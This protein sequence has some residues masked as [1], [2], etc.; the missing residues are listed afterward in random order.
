MFEVCGGG[1]GGTWLW[2]VPLGGIEP[3]GPPAPCT[4]TVELPWGHVCACL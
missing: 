1:G 3:W 2:K 4:S